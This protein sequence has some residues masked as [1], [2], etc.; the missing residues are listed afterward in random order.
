V[1]ER[2]V[3]LASEAILFGIVTEPHQGDK[4]RRG[5]ILLTVGAEHH[6]GSSRMYVSLARHWARHGYTVMRLDLAGLGDSGT[7]PGRPNDEVFPPAAIEDIRI[8]VEFMRSRYGIGDITLG[9]L[10]SG[11]YH[12]L[13]A[14]I[15][16]LPVN[17]ILLVNPM[18]FLWN[19]GL[20]AGD[21]QLEVDVARNV[22][23]YRDRVFSAAIWKRILT[24][25]FNIWRIARILMQRPLLDFESKLHDLAR[26]F[27][28][29]M[30]RDLG[31]EL[32]EIGARGVKMVFVF[33]RGEPGLDVLRL[34]GGSAVKRL[35]DRCLIHIIDS[36]DHIFSHTATRE[37]LKRILSDEL[38]A[39]NPGD[40]DTPR[41]KLERGQ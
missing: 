3:F 22:G 29:H 37:E 15:A 32:E 31:W 12:S 36:A 23:F 25:R 6:I 33:A 26:S 11:A 38:F 13:R 16:A 19:E 18:N 30:R 9:G 35:G 34:Q 40:D 1:S 27:R 8:A 41:M 4:R 2:P 5:V 28:I 24:G 14:A 17:R 10:C 7:R 39:R 21:L 20:T